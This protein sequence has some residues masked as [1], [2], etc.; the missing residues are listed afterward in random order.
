MIYTSPFPAFA[1]TVISSS[2]RPSLADMTQPSVSKLPRNVD[3]E[4]EFVRESTAQKARELET[5][6]WK[7]FAGGG[8]VRTSPHCPVLRTDTTTLFRVSRTRVFVTGGKN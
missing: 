5:N 8:E 7:G 3:I 2:L 1:D 6:Q 4:V